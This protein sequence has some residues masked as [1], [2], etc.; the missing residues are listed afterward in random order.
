VLRRTMRTRMRAKL[1]A[2]KAELRRRR[3]QPLPELGAYVRA[4]VHGRVRYYGVPQNYPSLRAFTR[5][6][7]RLWWQALCRRSQQR[8]PWARMRRYLVR[9]IPRPTICHPYPFDRFRVMT[10]GGSRMR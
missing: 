8:V 3:H 5:A 9:W 1:H 4:V 6:I 10:Q 2:V 7:S